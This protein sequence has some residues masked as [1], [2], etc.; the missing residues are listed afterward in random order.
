MLVGIQ[1]HYAR[2]I[3]VKV[4]RGRLLDWAGVGEGADTPRKRLSESSVTLARYLRALVDVDALAEFDA[5]S[6]T[7]M[8]AAYVLHAPV[9]W[10]ES[11]LNGMRGCSYR[12]LTDL[13]L[14]GSELRMWRAEHGLS[15]ADVASVV[16]VSTKTVAR[17]E[18][19]DRVLARSW[20]H[21]LGDHRADVVRP[22]AVPSGRIAAA[23]RPAHVQDS[24]S[25]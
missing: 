3:V 7:S 22:G 6:S 21:A 19:K 25:G 12:S 18:N 2:D 20:R 4:T 23:S 16:G 5:P 9:W 17:V 14:L 11:V 1:F 10:S 15:Q 8:S 13:P 24:A